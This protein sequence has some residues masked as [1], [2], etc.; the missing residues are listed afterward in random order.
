MSELALQKVISNKAYA[1]D[2]RAVE[3]QGPSS[4]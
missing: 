2:Y 1:D 3:Q 4:C